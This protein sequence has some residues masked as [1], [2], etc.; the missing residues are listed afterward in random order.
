MKFYKKIR[1]SYN[2]YA[3]FVLGRNMPAGHYT[4]Q[5]LI[6]ISLYR[7][8]L[9]HFTHLASVHLIEFFLLYLWVEKTSHETIRHYLNG[10][11]RS[12]FSNIIFYLIDFNTV[13]EKNPILFKKKIKPFIS[14][15]YQCSSFLFS[16][17]ELLTV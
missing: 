3:I 8:S 5:N 12:C 17:V 15:S 1:Y 14:K 11:W 7:K 4:K 9:L 13:E 10:F 2:N 16:W 6:F